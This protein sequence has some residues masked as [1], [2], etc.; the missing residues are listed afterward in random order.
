[1]IRAAA[2][3]TLLA[4]PSVAGAQA[5][6]CPVPAGA[7]PVRPDVAGSGQPRRLRPIGGYTLAISWSPNLC[8]TRGDDPATRFQCRDGRF[9]WT[10]HGLWPDGVDAEWPQYCR[11]AQLL[12][13]RVFR[14][15]L[16]AT[17]SAQLM[18]HE[19]AKHG[20][21]MT[22]ET[23]A[24][25]FRRSNA[26]YGRL[27]YPDMDALSRQGRLTAGALAAAMAGVNPGLG[28]DMMRVTADRG[29]WLDEVWLCLDTR[30]RYRRCPAHQ[31][32]LARTAMLRIWR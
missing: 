6:S 27:R 19:W 14:A 21:C 7:L 12:P 30:F 26:L 32:G 16:C 8:R 24:S 31:G 9:G 20:T 25:Y 17:P 18:Q 1:M 15:G 13:P 11:P 5:Y 10:L 4:S 22:G 29:G 23:P 2:A 3:V 28:A